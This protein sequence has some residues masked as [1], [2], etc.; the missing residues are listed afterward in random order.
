M[1]TKEDA[2]DMDAFD[3][4]HGRGQFKEIYGGISAQRTVEIEVWTRKFQVPL[5]WPQISQ[6]S[7]NHGTR[8]PSRTVLAKD[9]CPKVR[10]RDVV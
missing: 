9:Q 7:M 2:F 4:V 6:F 10:S 8:S 3:M 5:S 1:T